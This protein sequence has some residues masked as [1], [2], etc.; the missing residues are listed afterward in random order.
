MY[1]Y[2]FKQFQHKILS[3][4]NLNRSYSEPLIKSVNSFSQK[5]CGL[6][7]EFGVYQGVS[8]TTAYEALP[9]WVFYGFD[10]FE[11][12][13]EIWREGY[14]QGFFNL[15]GKIPELNTQINLIKG[16]F[17]ESI[18]AWVKQYQNTYSI[19]DILHIDCDL[20]SSTKT[21][22]DNLDDLIYTNHT[23]LVFDELINYPDYEK[24]EIKALYEYCA[25]KQYD[26]DI[27]YCGGHNSEKVALR[28]MDLS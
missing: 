1:R 24:H 14:G 21:V 27:L 17:N 4:Y 8:I 6:Y 22:L 9:N 16:W 10:S 3:F 25:D 18:P 20:Y 15:N 11:G 13:P 2:S 7:L 12:L 23:I 28:L 19:V 5:S 26:I